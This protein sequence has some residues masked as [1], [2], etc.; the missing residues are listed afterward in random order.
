[1]LSCF[2][3]HFFRILQ[4]LEERNHILEGEI[5]LL[6]DEYR[7]LASRTNAGQDLTSSAHVDKVG[8]ATNDVQSS[9]GKVVHVVEG[10]S[11]SMPAARYSAGRQRTQLGPIADRPSHHA[12]QNEG[13]TGLSSDID[14]KTKE[15]RA[16]L[17]ELVVAQ[18]QSE[19]DVCISSHSF[20]VMFHGILLIACFRLES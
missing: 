6:Q 16:I 20:T 9:Q 2:S 12:S 3:D 7:T 1:M 8:S 5:S 15:A 13:M 19:D 18:G 11:M 10:P 4:N 14:A 17:D